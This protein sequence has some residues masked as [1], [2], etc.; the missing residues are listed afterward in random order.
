MVSQQE[1]ARHTDPQAD[2]APP[3]PSEPKPATPTLPTREK[4]D[5]LVKKANEGHP[6]SQAKLRKI[7]DQCPQIWQEAGDLGL[8]AEKTLIHLISKGEWLM[9]ESLKRKLADLRAQLAGPSPSP[10]E[11]LA[12]QRVIA[13]WAQ[14]YFIET[15]CLQAEGDVRER[16]YWLKRQ[17]QAHRRYVSAVKSLTTIRELLT[18]SAQ[19]QA[20]L[21][22]G[23]NGVDVGLAMLHG[24]NGN[25][26]NGN[27]QGGPNGVTLPQ[28]GGV[29]VPAGLN[30]KTVPTAP[31]DVPN[32]NGHG[33]INR[34]AALANNAKRLEDAPT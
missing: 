10:L 22:R 28:D 20:A 19:P 14:L 32:G 25:G 12:V 1:T 34:I 4:F 11:E 31:P 30:G 6:K 33:G 15:E 9:T 21:P 3:N 29:G 16:T 24:A 13:C 17:D 7:L 18:V 2:Q 23:R 5:R 27:G 8:H 26:H